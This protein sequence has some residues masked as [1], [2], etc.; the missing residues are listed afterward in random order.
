MKPH[1]PMP[2][3]RPHIVRERLVAGAMSGTSAD[4]VDVAIVR[5]IPPRGVE[6]L[7]FASVPFDLALRKSI[8]ETRSTGSG[9]LRTTCE[10]ARRV[11]P[12]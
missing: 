10:I 11:T 8:L 4:G 7:G 9:T 12:S 1:P 2:I 3:D 5:T 6:L